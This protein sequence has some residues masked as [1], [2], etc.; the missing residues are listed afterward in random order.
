ML[1]V[2]ETEWARDIISLVAVAT[3]SENVYK[4]VD[5]FVPVLAMSRMVAVRAASAIIA[6]GDLLV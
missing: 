6:F 1:E 4:F 2:S 3:V 5:I